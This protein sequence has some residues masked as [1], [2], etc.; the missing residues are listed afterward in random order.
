MHGP[1]RLPCERVLER[2]TGNRCGTSSRTRPC[3]SDPPSRNRVQSPPT[4]CRARPTTTLGQRSP[5]ALPCG[6]LCW[7]HCCKRWRTAAWLGGHC[8]VWGLCGY[9]GHAGG[10]VH[11][12][13]LLRPRSSWCSGRCCTTRS[14]AKARSCSSTRTTCAT[15]PS[16]SSSRTMT[17]GTHVQTHALLTRSLTARFALRTACSLLVRRGERRCTMCRDTARRRRSARGHRC[18]AVHPPLPISCVLSQTRRRLLRSSRARRCQ[19]RKARASAR[20]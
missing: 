1:L 3:S 20:R 2:T 6:D 13:P 7:R 15:S 4:L 12:Q 14:A 10:D 16:R 11:R 17:N 8:N 18:A 19:V 9:G 5:C